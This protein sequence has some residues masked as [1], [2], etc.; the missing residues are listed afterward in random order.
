MMVIAGVSFP[1]GPGDLAEVARHH[2]YEPVLLDH[3]HN[4]SDGD[5]YP[6][7]VRYETRLPD[8]VV[9]RS[10]V[11]LPLLESWVSEGRRLAPRGDLRFDQ[12]AASVSRSKLALSNVLIEAGMSAVLRS[13]AETIEQAIQIA[14]AYDYP[15]VFRAD[16]GYSSR[17]VWVAGSEEELRALWAG[18]SEER[19]DADFTGMR[20]V[21]DST[22]DTIVIEPWL[23]GE[24]W[25]FDCVVGPAGVA[26]I[27][28]CEKATTILAGKPVT[29]GY[30][31]AGNLSLWAEMQKA[32]E[33]WM[34]VLFTARYPSF[35]CFDVRR[36]PNGDLVPLDFGVRLG[37]DRIPLLVRRA[38][39]DGNPYA[40]ALD[41]ALSGNHS[42]LA[43]VSPGLAIIHAFARSIGTFKGIRL[44][45]SGEV[46]DSR[47]VGFRIEGRRQALTFRRVGSVL[48]HCADSDEFFKACRTAVHWIHVDF[49]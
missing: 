27:R 45:R 21:L 24:E 22:D 8:D 25:S 44:D 18:Q 16:A 15:V 35:A 10:G 40:A 47:P 30:R 43:K 34:A 26:I 28:L 32:A 17:G 39:S 29:L 38:T 19:A 33:R 2:G 41:A 3:P 42:R 14:A 46:I 9:S 4:S 31:I 36:H 48:V 13:R 5:S 11:L 23:T 6:L 12:H 20:T 37:G 49:Y 1:C 7:P